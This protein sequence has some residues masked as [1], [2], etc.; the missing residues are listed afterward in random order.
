MNLKELARVRGTNIKRLA[1]QCGVPASTLYAISSGD[2]NFDNV[3][4]G[5]FLKISEALGMTA[6]ELYYITSEPTLSEL[7]TPELTE[8]EQKLLKAF[9]SM[10]ERGKRLV[11]AL[12]DYRGEAS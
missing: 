11:L 12:C 2:T 9:R 8:Q 3:G 5:L 6:D 1:E 10:D 7:P 4:I